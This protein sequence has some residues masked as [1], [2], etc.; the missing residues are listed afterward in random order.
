MV[1]NILC[2]FNVGTLKRHDKWVPVT[3]TSRVLRLRMEERLPVW[4]VAANILNKQLR[5]AN[6]G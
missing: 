6:K 3:M 1:N 5:I 2:V 4:R